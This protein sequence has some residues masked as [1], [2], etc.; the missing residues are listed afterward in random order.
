MTT[1]PSLGECQTFAK[2]FLHQ[3]FNTN[4]VVGTLDKVAKADHTVHPTG[5]SVCD[6][7]SSSANVY[8][9]KFQTKKQEQKWH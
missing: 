1:L 6:A 3:N 4:Q 8:R 9:K 5:W 2:A 7:A